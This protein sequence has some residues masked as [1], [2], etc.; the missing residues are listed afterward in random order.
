MLESMHKDTERARTLEHM[1][2]RVPRVVRQMLVRHG[3]WIVGQMLWKDEQPSRDSK[4]E[5]YPEVGRRSAAERERSTTA[6]IMFGRYQLRST[7]T[8]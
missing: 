3:F 2:V 8:E 4:I 5:T 1:H 6:A 7:K